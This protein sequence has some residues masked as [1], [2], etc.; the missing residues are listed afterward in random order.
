MR[1]NESDPATVTP[2]EG[3]RILGAKET[4]VVRRDDELFD[5]PAIA[6]EEPEPPSSFTHRAAV[7]IVATNQPGDD[8]DEERPA[9]PDPAGGEVPPLPH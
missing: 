5:L 3:V 6:P 4:P 9:P 2:V 7:P 8:D 1:D